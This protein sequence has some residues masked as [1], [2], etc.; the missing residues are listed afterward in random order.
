MRPIGISVLI[1]L[2][3]VGCATEPAGARHSDVRTVPLSEELTNSYDLAWKSTVEAISGICPVVTADKT[4]GGL[5]TTWLYDRVYSS[6]RN[7]RRYR[8]RILASLKHSNQQCPYIIEF[9]TEVQTGHGSNWEPFD[10]TVFSRDVFLILMH[11][12]GHG[13]LHEVDR[14]PVASPRIRR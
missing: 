14:P 7:P 12:V 4:T 5:T 2:S 10:A 6:G 13:V 9:R 3:S 8:A 1:A 11:K